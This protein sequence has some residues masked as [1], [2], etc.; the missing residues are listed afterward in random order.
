MKLV[1]RQPSGK[2]CRDISQAS[3]I[4]RVFAMRG[5]NH[6]D[7]LEVGL[8]KLHPIS[9]LKDIEKAT[10]LLVDAIINHQKI[11]VIGD[12]DADGATST[13]LTVRAIKA[14][15]HEQIDYL[16]PNRF[17]YGYGLT[18]EI[19]IEAKKFAPA[20]IVT[21]DNGIS[22][23]KG[24]E[25]A[26][27]LGIKVLITDHHLP[28]K[29]IPDA[30][31]IINP[32]Q[33]G[34]TFP[35]KN[36]AGVGVAFYLMLALKLH[37]QKIN[38]F[39][40]NKITEPNL[41]E[42][43]DLVALG[44]VADVVTLDQNNRILVEQGLRRMRSG[45]AS[46]GI[47][48]L[49]QIAKRDINSAVST[50]LGFACGPRLNAAGRLDDM[51]LGI[52]CLLTEDPAQAFEYAAALD[53]LN[54][55]RREIEEAMKTEAM[56]LLQELDDEK[57]SGDLPPVLCL[58]K[59]TWHQGVIG[60][61]AARVRERY[62]RPT[63]IF[64]PA[65]DENNREIKG[66]ARSI[67]TI[68]IRDIFDEVASCHPGLLEKFGGHAMAAGLTLEKSRLKEFT[69][70]ICK[71]VN[72]HADE[73]T[74]QEILHSDGK[75]NE[76]EFDLKYA[77]ELRFAAPWGQNFPTPNFD[78][79]FTIVK[80]Q[81]IKNHHLKLS[82]RPKGLERTVSAIAFNVDLQDWP[83]E[84]TEVHLLYKLEVNEYRGIRSLQLLIEK[85]LA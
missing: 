8:N 42:L 13:A 39:S 1:R 38:Y 70:A 59:E 14:M 62:N 55:E 67:S 76:E 40:H 57:L 12:F 23:I 31:A 72:K 85:R 54:I 27:L 37:L 35:S 3:L 26:K 53:D 33:G 63:I 9:A 19:V 64:A 32:N 25:K 10:E 11:L 77:G 2:L 18:P 78:N 58:Y 20:L 44:T 56:Q 49:F 73:T 66:S 34:D 68:H 79:H 82:L 65:D 83:I 50:D 71:I 74:F 4:E 21:V 17:E 46:E 7:E 29:E 15:G 36:L 75:L 48:A 69:Q 51:S 6:Q 81:A 47:K 52:E 43:L 60:I 28:A 61:L 16:V 80:K 24:V 41:A 22:S 45:N 5:I 30:D 84:G